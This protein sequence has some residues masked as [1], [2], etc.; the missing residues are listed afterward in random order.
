MEPHQSINGTPTKA[1]GPTISTTCPSTS[2][3]W[4]FHTIA[5]GTGCADLLASCGSGSGAEG[6]VKICDGLP[7]E[8]AVMK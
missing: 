6:S 7:C 4:S 3:G 5:C 8:G 2:I 1:Y